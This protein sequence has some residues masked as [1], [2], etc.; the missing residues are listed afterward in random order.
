M[1]MIVSVLLILLCVIQFLRPNKEYCLEGDSLFE[2]GISAGDYPVYEG[3]RLSPGVYQV[4]LEYSCDTDMLNLCHIQDGTVMQQGLLTHGVHLYSGL[5]EASFQVWLFEHTDALQVLVQ[6]CGQGSL[7]VENLHIYETDQLWSMCLTAALFFTVLIMAVQ[8]LKLYDRT[9]SISGENKNV[10]FALLVLIL[11]SSVP[12]L[13]GMTSNGADL[14]YHLHRIEGIKDGILSGQFP[15][16]LEPQWV[17]GYGY[18]NGIFYCG[19]FLLFPALLRIA[20]FPVTFSYNCYCI[21]LNIATVLISFYSFSKIFRSKYI[22]VAGS[23][24]YTMSVFRIYKLLITSAVGEGSAV[25]F[26]PLIVYGFWRVFGEDRYDR[27]YRTSWVPLAFGY[28]GL[29]QTHVLSCEIAALITVFICIAFIRKIFCRERFRELCKG[30][31]GALVLSLWFLVP[32][33]DYYLREDLHIKH[34]FSRPIQERGLY[35]AQLM[36]NWW[37]YGD[38]ALIGES[39]MVHSHALGVGFVLVLG[40]LVMGALWFS[41]RLK[42]AGEPVWKLARAAWLLSG[43]LMLMSLEVFPWDKIQNSSR[44]TSALVS[45]L[46]FPNRFL[47]WGSV[48]LVIVFCSLLYYFREKKQDILYFSGLLCVLVSLASSGMYLHEHVIRDKD[49]LILYN[50]EGMGV[51]YISGAEYLIEGTEEEKLLYR[52]PVVSGDVNIS[53]YEKG[54]LRAEFYCE[55]TGTQEGYVELPLL[56]YYGYRAR[57]GDE[58]TEL[59]VCKGDNNVV[60]VVIPPGCHTQVVVRFMS[61]W[62]WRIAE[63]ISLIGGVWILVCC[64]RYCIGWQGNRKCTGRKWNP[65]RKGES[66]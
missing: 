24:L 8:F 41:G 16:R 53:R 48:F 55:N 63:G 37:R 29:I 20:G 59:Q 46:Q 21:L 9:Y 1:I 4:V 5:H 17:Q 3:I 10:M 56:H 50:P 14:I 13:T 66:A 7:R 61:P 45:S 54:A 32:F 62:Y 34:V 25:T 26:M 15:V 31:A 28:A 40:F 49:Q 65:E 64:L 6:Y 30:A 42:D 60:R 23:A 51:G 19:T 52:E 57:A 27:R 36:F 44:L 18:A 39:G 33:L 47:G 58:G 38:N 43:I 11:I 2:E 35:L 22:G 12:Y